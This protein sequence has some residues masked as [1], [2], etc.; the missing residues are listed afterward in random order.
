MPQLN[1]KM[2]PLVILLDKDHAVA[3]VFK[4]A[5]LRDQAL[6]AEMKKLLEPSQAEAV[7]KR[8]AETKP[9]LEDLKQ[10][11]KK[12]ASLKKTITK[13]KKSAHRAAGKKLEAKL[14]QR[15]ELEK[16]YDQLREKLLK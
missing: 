12:W 15:A 9:V 16:E 6:T 2:A 13:L 11:R 10:L 7:D 8:I 14:K 5:R 4:K 1:E 3:A